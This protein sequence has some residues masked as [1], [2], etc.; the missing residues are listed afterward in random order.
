MKRPIA[1]IAFL[2]AALCIQAQAPS[3]TLCGRVI[4]QSSQKGISDAAVEVPGSDYAA[5]TNAEGFFKIAVP[6]KKHVSLSFRHLS[7][8]ART[9]EIDTDAKDS[10]YLVVAL[11]EKEHAL[12]NV[13]VYSSFKPDT[14]VSSPRFSIY[15]FDFYEDYFILLT[16][17]KS[18]EKAQLKLADYS[19]RVLHTVDLPQE[20]GMAKELYHD[21]MGYTN[22]ICEH[23]IYR[24]NVFNNTLVLMPI[25]AEDYNAFVKPVIDTINGKLI[26]SDYWK[27]YPLFNYYAYNLAD[28]S[29]QSLLTITNEDLLEAYN[30]EYYAMKPR[31][32]L[33]ARR[34]AMDLKTDKRIIAALMTGFTKSMFYEPLYAP[35]F[36][37][38]DTL[39]I[40]DHY[41]DMLF[42]F[43]K[44]GRRLDSVAI[45]YNHPKN[46]H[47]W[48][49]VMVKDELENAIYAVYDRNGHKYL[50][51]IDH[52]T[53]K[54]RG[55]YSL[56]FYSADKIK[57]RDGYAY[58]IYRP[59]ESTQQKFLYREL[60]RLENK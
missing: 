5:V 12:G 46:W 10:I 32:K 18:L 56:Q 36:I 24:V 26:F 31:E 2:L 20:A 57:V 60:I 38:K 3:V 1:F 14:L 19:G 30:F 45:S 4:S 58:Y 35:L 27:D 40:F 9:R 6:R 17:Y 8:Q 47:D 48:K 52:R 23:S 15:D 33:E 42:H 21:Y 29:R 53:G 59:F 55:L 43:D 16:A 13:D 37:L 54:D 22:V 51:Q 28:S 34:M 39:C 50:R 44:Q 11:T 7:Y 25:D 49:R 41:R